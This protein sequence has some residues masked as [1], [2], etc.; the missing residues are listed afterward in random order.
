MSQKVC[1]ELCRCSPYAEL[2]SVTFDMSD[3]GW[4]SSSKHNLRRI[5]YSCA[6]SEV[7]QYE[8][9]VSQKYILKIYSLFN[10]VVMPF[11]FICVEIFIT[12]FVKIN[13]LAGI[14][15]THSTAEDGTNHRP[16][17]VIEFEMSMLFIWWIQQEVNKIIHINTTGNALEDGSRIAD[18]ICIDESCVCSVSTSVASS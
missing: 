9:L 11:T 14:N 10:A 13:K 16:K 2:F 12:F 5:K 3:D 17:F 6:S 7:W 8:K 15:I 18:D 1:I 4:S